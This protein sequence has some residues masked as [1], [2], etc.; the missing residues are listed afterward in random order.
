MSEITAKKKTSRWPL[1]GARAGLGALLIAGF[2]FFMAGSFGLATRTWREGQVAPATL[3]APWSFTVGGPDRPVQV[4]RGELLVSKGERLTAAHVARLNGMDRAQNPGR[5]GLPWVGAWLLSSLFI[6]VGS[7]YLMRFEK[8][9]WVSPRGLVLIA[10][11]V[12][13]ILLASRLVL[14]SPFVPPWVPVAAVSMMLSMLLNPRLGIGIGLL[15]AGVVILMG[16]ADFPLMIGLSVGCFVGAYAVQGIRRRMDFFRAG[17]I[18]GLAQ[19]I[20]LFGSHLL[21][22]SPVLEGL[23]EGMAALGSGV[24]SGLITFCLLPIFESLFGLITDVT[25]VELS[26]LNHPLLKELSVKAPGTYHHSIIVANLA[27]AACQ[28]IGANALLARVGCYFHDIG[29]MLHPEYFVENQPPKGSRHDRLSPSMSS[30]V[31]LNHVKEGIDLAQGAR[32]NQAIIDFIPGHHGTGLIYYF[33]RRAMEQTENQTELKEERFRYPG[34]KPQAR[35]T[36]VAL[37]ADS[38]EA[39]TRVLSQKSPARIQDLVRRIL[40]NKFIDGQMDECDLTL[41]DLEKISEVFQRVLAG[42]YHSRI[43]YP[44]LPGEEE[45]PPAPMVDAG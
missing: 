37:L 10:V 40:N 43:E 30:L 16:Q 42:I 19:G 23:T 36:A 41:R 25:L 5:N 31:I 29:K 11:V 24:L 45:E 17:L 20:A 13:L 14:L 21:V 44:K 26:D 4:Q 8:K 9:V 22:Q 7:V 12:G 6:V 3:Y 33:Y 27:E 18:T 34:P 38:V 35:E 39:A 15:A 1:F 28:E 2:T 32:L